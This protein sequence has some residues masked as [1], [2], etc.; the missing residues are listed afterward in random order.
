MDASLYFTGGHPF[1][2]M[3]LYDSC[4]ILELKFL[5]VLLKEESVLINDSVVYL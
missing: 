5:V 2:Y 3:N 4:D 1:Y